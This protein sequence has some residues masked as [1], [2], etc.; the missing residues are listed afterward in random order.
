LRGERAAATVDGVYA[1]GRGRSRSYRYRLVD[2][3]GH[4]VPGY[5][6]E[7]WERF[8]VG[9]RVTVVV[10][11]DGVVAPETADEVEE[12]KALWI[13]NGV[14]FAATVFMALWSARMR[15]REGAHRHDS[16]GR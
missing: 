16:G 15:P 14:A 12:A 11:P 10:D 9:S 5:L 6:R 1:V 8:T 7:E 13:I 4:R 2:A 3:G